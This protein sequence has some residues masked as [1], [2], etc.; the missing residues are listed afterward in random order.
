[1]RRNGKLW[2]KTSTALEA[3]VRSFGRVLHV[4]VR[5]IGDEKWL[6]IALEGSA[7]AS[8]VDQVFDDHSHKAFGPYKTQKKAVAILEA[9]AKEWKRQ[10]TVKAFNR[11]GC[12]EIEA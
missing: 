3:T 9:F 1:M 6:A 10:R 4:G 7:G 5:E 12:A 2:W 11:C 8:T